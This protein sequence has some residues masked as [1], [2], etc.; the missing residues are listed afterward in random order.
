FVSL[1]EGFVKIYYTGCHLAI[2]DIYVLDSNRIYIGTDNN[3]M[4]VFD[5]TTE[6]F[7]DLS[8]GISKFNFAKS[9]VHS[10]MMDSSENLWLG[11]YQK[12]IALIPFKRNN[13]KYIGYQSINKNSIGSNSI[14]GLQKG[15]NG[16]MW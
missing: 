15:N 5:P 9:K 7:S 11:I 13:F 8:L 10:I 14:T 16:I 6:T 12:G 1:E 3:G 2:K 4:K